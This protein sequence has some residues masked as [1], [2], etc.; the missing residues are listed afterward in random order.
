MNKARPADLF[1]IRWIIFALNNNEQLDQSHQVDDMITQSCRW[2][3][4]SDKYVTSLYPHVRVEL[5][6]CNVEENL[7]GFSDW[8]GRKQIP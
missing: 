5:A 8:H 3:I 2:L 4:V 1:V 6:C 7:K